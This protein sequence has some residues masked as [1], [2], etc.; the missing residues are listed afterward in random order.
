MKSEKKSVV[1]LTNFWDANALIDYGFML[2]KFKDQE[3]AYQLNLIKNKVKERRNYSVHSIALRH[4]SL[5]NLPNLGEKEMDCVEHFCPT[6]DLLRRYK[7]DRNWQSYEK[8]YRKLLKQRKS[9]LKAWLNSL[10][11]QHVY[12][13]CCWENTAAGAHCHRDILF[14]L[15]NRSRSAREKLIVIYV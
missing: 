14:D 11:S 8:D 1:V 13:L 2:F 12:I 9:V 15:F 5:K 4:P 10:E 6:Y 7:E 3:T